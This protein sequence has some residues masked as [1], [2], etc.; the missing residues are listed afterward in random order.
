MLD[1]KMLDFILDSVR[2][3]AQKLINNAKFNTTKICTIVSNE[4]TSVTITVESDSVNIPGVKF[5]AGQTLS[6]GNKALLIKTN[7][8]PSS[9]DW[10][11]VKLS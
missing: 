9:A 6:A 2:K 8:S 4:T 1:N 3:I 5:V 7:N 10:Y 11:V